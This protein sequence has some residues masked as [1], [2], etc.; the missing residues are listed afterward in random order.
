[1]KEEMKGVCPFCGQEAFVEAETQEEA[2]LKAAQSCK[3]D[4]SVKRI[5]LLGQN[6]E[7]LTG[8]EICKFNMEALPEETTEA[9]KDIGSLCVVGEI[10][11][12]TVRVPDSTIKIRRTKRGI[13][14]SRMK[15]LSA[16][17]E[18]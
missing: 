2:D 6:I 18:A 10:E 1:M 12:V 17:L 3:C 8:P 9:L 11:A 13:S 14:V 5:Y 15:A 7:K 16:T 4:N